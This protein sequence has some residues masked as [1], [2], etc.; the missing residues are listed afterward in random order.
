VSTVIDLHHWVNSASQTSATETARLRPASQQRC[1]HIFVL[2]I[3]SEATESKWTIITDVSARPA[4]SR[5]DGGVT[6]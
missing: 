1:Y 6:E 2:D 5:W 4:E 3:A